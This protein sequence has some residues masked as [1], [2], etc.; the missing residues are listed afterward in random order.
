[1]D[2]FYYL[3]VPI[4]YAIP[5]VYYLVRKPRES[6]LWRKVMLLSVSGICLFLATT[7]LNSVRLYHVSIP[8]IILLCYWFQRSRWRL[9]PLIGMAVVIPAAFGLALWGQVKKYP[10]LVELPT[11]RVVFTSEMAGEKYVWLN[12]RTEPGDVVF[13]P[14]R[15]V[16]NFPLKLRNPTSFATLR[17]NNYT[18]QQQVEQ[19][20]RELSANPPKYVLWDGNWTKV[21]TERK[22]DDHLRPLQDWLRSRYELRQALTPVFG[23]EIQVWEIKADG[24]ATDLTK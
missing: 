1:M 22:P 2:L 20:L 24:G 7:G 21:D 4:V 18:T 6:Q 3:L 5:V 14:Y 17:D 8:G 13:E 16:V 10:S 9:V 15:T 12:D 23:I 11:G 19:I